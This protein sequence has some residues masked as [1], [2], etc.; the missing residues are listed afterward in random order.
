MTGPE[1]ERLF[2][3]LRRA[4]SRAA[5]AFEELLE[6]RERTALPRRWHFAAGLAAALLAGG[7][8]IGMLWKSAPPAPARPPST[9]VVLVVR[10]WRAPLDFLLTTPDP[11]RVPDQ[12]P[13]KASHP[14][15]G[16]LE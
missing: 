3:K 13:V 12:L 7:V 1:L 14:D 4:E 15:R 11:A 16:E 8:G 10:E 2:E 6:P 9:R 5:P